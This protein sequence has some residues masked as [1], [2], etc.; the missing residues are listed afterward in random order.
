M[1]ASCETPNLTRVSFKTGA[2]GSMIQKP[3]SFRGLLHVLYDILFTVAATF[4]TL[5][6]KLTIASQGNVYKDGVDSDI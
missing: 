1:K 4:N 2:Y 5:T 3:Y 6:S